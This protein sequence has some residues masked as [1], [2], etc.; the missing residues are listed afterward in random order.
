M[1][2]STIKQKNRLSLHKRQNK[3]LLYKAQNQESKIA[4]GYL[5]LA[6]VI[7]GIFYYRDFANEEVNNFSNKGFKNTSLLYFETNQNNYVF[8]QKSETKEDAFKKAKEV[9]ASG[10]NK[11]WILHL[12]D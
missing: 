12:T 8:T 1:I 2:S 7:L 3:N 6:D 4:M 10:G 5:L 9:N 11:A